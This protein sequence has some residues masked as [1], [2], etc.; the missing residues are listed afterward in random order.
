MGVKVTGTVAAGWETVRAEFEAVVAAQPH[1]P[2]AQLAVRHHGRTVVDLWAGEDTD[3]ETLSGVFSITKGAAHLVVALL[4]QDGA[5]EPDRPVVSYWPE[6]TGH[7]KERLTVRDLLAHRSGLI[8]T[9]E[10]FTIEELADD[11]FI[12]ARL[13]SAEPYW[14]PGTAYGYHAFVIGALTGEVV[15]R[16]TGRSIRE[17][18]EERVRAPYGLDLYMGLPSEAQ[19]RWKPIL[20]ALPTPAQLEIQAAAGPMPELLPVAFNWHTDPPMDLVAFANHPLVKAQGPASAGGVGTAAG[21]A[22]MYAAAIGEVDGRPALLKPETVAEFAKLHTPG[23]DRVVLEPDHFGLGFERQPA[24]GPEAFGHCGAAGANG[25][26]DPVTGIAYGYTRR[27]FG[28]PGGTAPENLPL[29][30]AVLKVARAAS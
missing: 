7:G 12:A 24:V 22:G 25:F 3:G 18:Y 15:R 11:A 17:I 9:P 16:A 8:N 6:F 29:T 1:S 26:A 20:E 28:F 13:A 27:R 23:Q 30:A 10:G 19:E 14:E 5:L 4:V 2:E 21:I